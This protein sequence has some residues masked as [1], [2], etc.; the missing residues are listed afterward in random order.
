MEDKELLSA[1]EKIGELYG[2]QKRTFD[3]FKFQMQSNDYRKRTFE[4]LAGNAKEVWGY[5][6][7]DRFNAD[8]FL[9]APSLEIND[10]PTTADNLPRFSASSSTFVDNST[11]V[12]RDAM[13]NPK[14]M[15]GPGGSSRRISPATQAIIDANN[16]KNE[17]RACSYNGIKACC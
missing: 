7:Y 3:E 10:T 16:D 1:W 6:N 15:G 11:E 17:V 8:K 9:P 12:S 5:D 2:P 13:S 4:N 14:T